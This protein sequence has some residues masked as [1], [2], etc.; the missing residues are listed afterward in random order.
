MLGILNKRNGIVQNV[1]LHPGQSARWKDVIVRLRACETTAPWEEEKLTGAF[2][3]V[4]VQEQRQALASRLLRLA[5]QGIAVAQRGRAPG[6]RRLAQELRD[7]ISG[8]SAGA[9]GAGHARATCRARGNRAARRR[10]PGA[11]PRAA[12]R[13][14]PRR[15]RPKQCDI[16]LARTR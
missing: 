7:D 10:R 9:R 13:R 1:A 12:R 4:D 15:A 11:R 14:R 3:Q 16:G 8:G 5:L 6:L 2:V